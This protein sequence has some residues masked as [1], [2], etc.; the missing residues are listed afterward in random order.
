[1]RRIEMRIVTSPVKF[2]TC[3]GHVRRS[4]EEAISNVPYVTLCEL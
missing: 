3:H 2:I 1:M 4:S